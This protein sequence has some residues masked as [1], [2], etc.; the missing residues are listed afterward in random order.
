LVSGPFAYYFAVVLEKPYQWVWY[1]S[2]IAI[3]IAAGTSITWLVLRVRKVHR[4]VEAL[5]ST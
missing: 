4:E 2:V 3:F 1:A 5:N